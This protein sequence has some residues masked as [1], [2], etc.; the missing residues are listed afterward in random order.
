[1]RHSF[2]GVPVHRGKQNSARK[3][4]TLFANQKAIFQKKAD[5]AGYKQ[6]G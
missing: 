3:G 6:K 4:A 2:G 5:K 1:L